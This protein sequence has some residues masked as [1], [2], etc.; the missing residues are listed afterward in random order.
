M[1]IGVG[2]PAHVRDGIDGDTVVAWAERAEA[3]EFATL[4]AGDRLVHSTPEPLIT[5]TAAAAVTSRIRLATAALVAPVRA[6]HAL[7]ATQA[8]TLDNIAGP[9]RLR[10]GLEPGLR[11]DDYEASGVS[12][13]ARGR[14]FDAQLRTLKRVWASGVGPAPATPGGPELMFGGMSQATLRRIRTLGGGWC[15]ADCSPDEFGRFAALARRAWSDGGHRGEPPMSVSVMFALG[16]DAEA[17]VSAE[18]RAYYAY[19]GEEW[20]QET[21]D[22]ACTDEK[23]VRTAA[24]QFEGAGCQ[25]VVFT[26]NNRD[27]E[28]VDLLADALG[29]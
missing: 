24:E 1:N 26:A 6:N 23:G 11:E 16:P 5:L 14:T 3:R 28:Q 29:L 22:R 21:V 20:L 10:L 19:V 8:A 27:P 13:A 18:L 2:L 4:T 12:F 9:G 7:F 15:A 25:E 17:R